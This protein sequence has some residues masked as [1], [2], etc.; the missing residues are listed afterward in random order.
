MVTEGSKHPV[1]MASD[2]KSQVAS[3]QQNR[4]S[5]T[6]VSVLGTFDAQALDDVNKPHVEHAVARIR[7]KEKGSWLLCRALV[8][9]ENHGETPIPADNA[10]FIVFKANVPCIFYTNNLAFTPSQQIMEPNEDTVRCVHGLVPTETWMNVGP[11]HCPSKQIPAVI[12]AYN[13]LRAGVNRVQHIKSNPLPDS[14]TFATQT[15]ITILVDKNA[16]HTMSL[17]RTAAPREKQPLIFTSPEF[18]QSICDAFAQSSEDDTVAAIKAENE[19]TLEP[20]P[21][22]S[23]QADHFLFESEGGRHS[24]CYLCKHLRTDGKRSSSIYSCSACQHAFHV[25]CF[26]MY[27]YY[28]KLRQDKPE[29]FQEIRKLHV[30]HGRGQG[31]RRDRKFKRTVTF[32]SAKLPFDSERQPKDPN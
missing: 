28:D 4:L 14:K 12:A 11:D 10:G 21:V 25:N 3:T 30:S 15:D 31:K 9:P 29:L 2:R 20:P 7:N 19:H 24:Q 17:V 8:K 18:K 1:I 6:S 13:T 16:Q 22:P 23:L 26:T 5:A 32:S 27:H